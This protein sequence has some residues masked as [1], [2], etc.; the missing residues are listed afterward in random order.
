MHLQI[1]YIVITI[2]LYYTIASRFIPSG[3][4]RENVAPNATSLFRLVHRHQPLHT[5][6]PWG[7]H[8]FDVTFLQYLLYCVFKGQPKSPS[9]N[10]VI[11]F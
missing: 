9:T 1:S 11:K 3:V 8:A 10:I 7:P 5:C 2:L 6:P 4:V